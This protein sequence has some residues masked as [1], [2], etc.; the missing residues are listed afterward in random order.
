MLFW[1]QAYSGQVSVLHEM[2]IVIAI[3][4]KNRKRSQIVW[5]VAPKRKKVTSML[6][7]WQAYSGQIS[8]P[9]DMNI[10][11]GIEKKKNGNAHK[12]CGT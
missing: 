1:W 9:N 3:K 7:W 11:I 10:V 2:Q 5:N 8:V 6:F 4:K 12:L